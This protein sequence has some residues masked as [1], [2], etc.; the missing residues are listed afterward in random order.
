MEPALYSELVPWYRLVD[1]PE[2]HLEEATDYRLALERGAAHRPETL[3]DLGAG[4]LCP[5]MG[6]CPV[7][8]RSARQFVGAGR[9]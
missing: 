9:G 1:P 8:L 3:L 4:G 6:V 5:T 7:I 2:D